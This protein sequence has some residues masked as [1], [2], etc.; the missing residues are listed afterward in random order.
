MFLGS[1]AWSFVY[2]SLPFH[3]Q[4]V[5]TWDPVS[6]LRWTGWILGISPLASVATAPFWGRI[7]GR[8]DP[9]GF[10]VATQ[11]FQ[12]AAFLGMALAR[13]LPEM[14]LARL[15]LGFMGAGSAFAFI[16]AGRADDAGEVRG[17]IAAM[18]SAMT[19]VQVIGP[20]CGGVAA[21]RLGFRDSF[22]LRG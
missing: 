2:V 8:R 6:A 4:R 21:A 20:R 1:F 7:A 13:T 14:F 16:S 15:V 3:V 17:Q 11:Y 22:L 18:Q 9:K 10:F 12:G 19:V 5:S